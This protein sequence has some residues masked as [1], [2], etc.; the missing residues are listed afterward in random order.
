MNNDMF[1]SVE[2]GSRM[3]PLV[4]GTE[5][6]PLL[7]VLRDHSLDVDRLRLDG[8]GKLSVQEIGTALLFSESYPRTLVRIDVD[9]ERLRFGPLAVIGKRVHEILGLFKVSR[10]TTLWCNVENKSETSDLLV[11]VNIAEQSRQ[12]LARGTIWI[13]GLGLGLTLRDGLVATVHLCHPTHA[14]RSGTGTWTKE[15][16]RLSEVRE[17]PVISL[18][19]T[20]RNRNRKMILSV[21]IHRATSFVFWGIDQV[22]SE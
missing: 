17:I 10:K 13:P 9:D 2:L 21:M 14:P 15:Q 1:W 20:V 22:D 5:Y 3:G 16:Q 18:A 12:L 6:E 4:L 8:S 19:P 7:Q 11:N